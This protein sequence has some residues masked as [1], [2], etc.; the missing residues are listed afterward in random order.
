M[1]SWSKVLVLFLCSVFL[2]SL[3]GCSGKSLKVIDSGDFEDVMDD[4][5]YYADVYDDEDYLEKGQV[6]MAY[7]YDEDY[8]YYAIF[9][10]YEDEE[11]AVDFFNDMFDDL[12]DAKDDDE[13][14][15]SYTKTT[16]KNYQ[17][18][19]I[20][21]EFEDAT[22]DFDEGSTYQIAFQIDKTIIAVMAYDNGKSDKKEVDKIVKELGY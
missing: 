9:V 12:K 19:V 6:E 7:A 14:D 20:D 17:K 5:D 21:G 13:F 15:G 1:K 16:G 4:L 8:E 2:F 22:G 3:V 11:D 18:I 10:E